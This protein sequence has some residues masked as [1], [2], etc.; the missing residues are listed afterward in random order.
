MIYY[1]VTFPNGVTTFCT[2][3]AVSEVPSLFE[4]VRDARAD[5]T[6]ENDQIPIVFYRKRELGKKTID[7]ILKETECDK[8]IGGAK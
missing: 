2:R 8:K 1:S 4:L 6:L 7:K 3:N 5:G